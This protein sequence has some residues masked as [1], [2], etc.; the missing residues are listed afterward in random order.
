MIE[1]LGMHQQVLREILVK[2]RVFV[3]F[4]VVLPEQLVQM[5][6]KQWRRCGSGGLFIWKVGLK[7]ENF[8]LVLLVYG[9]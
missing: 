5:L 2:V 3:E 1:F 8:V 4:L 9:V 7:S 6:V